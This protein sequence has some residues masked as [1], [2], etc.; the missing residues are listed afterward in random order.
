VV[1]ETD[2]VES[3]DEPAPAGEE[4]ILTRTARV[5]VSVMRLEKIRP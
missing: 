1:T 5:A 4:P 3:F 2:K